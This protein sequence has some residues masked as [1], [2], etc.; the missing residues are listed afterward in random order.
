[1][2]R[3]GRFALA[4]VLS[5]SPVAAQKHPIN[6]CEASSSPAGLPAGAEYGA[7]VDVDGRWT[8]VGA[9]GDGPLAEQGSTF[10]SLYGTLIAKLRAQAPAVGQRFGQ[11]V[12]ISG[13]DAVVGAPGDGGGSVSVHRFVPGAPSS[14]RL[15][16][17]LGVPGT[18]LFGSAVAIEAGVLVVGA[19][20]PS[21]GR[22]FVFDATGG[23]HLVAELQPP[24]GLS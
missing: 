21:H 16:A 20:D 9:P 1:M 3:D 15:S 5:A 22:V 14:F 6:T 17:R 23:W 8:I 4:V 11:A 18:L 2:I 24:G 13:N 19:P 10:V 12:G 7:S